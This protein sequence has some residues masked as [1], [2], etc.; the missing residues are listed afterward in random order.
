[1]KETQWGEKIEKDMEKVL[2]I[3]DNVICTGMTLSNGTFNRI[4]ECVLE[5]NI[6]LTV[7]AQT[8]SSIIAQFI[9]RGVT[10]LVA[11]PFPFSQFNAGITQLYCY[12]AGV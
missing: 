8:G 2:N 12:K 3:A 11:E 5:K 6:P 1:M 10:S 9:G 7:Y 4:L